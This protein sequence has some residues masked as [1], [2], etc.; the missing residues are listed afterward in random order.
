M[1]FFDV[2]TGRK[3][4]P[5]GT[6]RQ[7]AEDLRAALL[8]L[9]RSTAPFVVSEGGPEG[10]DLT[11]EWRIVDARWYEIFAK[12]GLKKGAQV[13]LKL[14]EEMG[15]VRNI[16]RDYTIEWRAGLPSLSFSAEGFRGQKVEMSFG[17]SGFDTSASPSRTRPAGSSSIRAWVTSG[18]RR[19][20]PPITTNGR[21]D[22]GTPV[23]TGGSPPP[24]KGGLASSLPTSFGTAMSE[25]SRMIRPAPDQGM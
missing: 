8:A 16:Q 18:R 24:P 21:L 14:N 22:S 25:M 4:P 13:L 7:S 20:S 9:N 5:A 23:C 2:F 11:A 1:G 10:A 15:E 17:L 12:A 3:A 19:P 6:P